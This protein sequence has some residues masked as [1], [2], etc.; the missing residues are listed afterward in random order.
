[1]TMIKMMKLIRMILIGAPL[2]LKVTRLYSTGKQ[3][4][5]TSK[6]TRGHRRRHYDPLDHRQGLNQKPNQFP[7]RQPKNQRRHRRRVITW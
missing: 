3:E 1:M 7:P 2:R 6:A 4:A 5:G